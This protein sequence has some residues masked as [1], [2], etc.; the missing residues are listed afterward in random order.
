MAPKAPAKKGPNSK[1]VSV[2]VKEKRAASKK[3]YDFVY[4]NWKPEE[5]API[6]LK[7]TELCTRWVFGYEIGDSGTPHLQGFL[8]LKTKDRITGIQSNPELAHFSFRECRNEAALI[9]YCNGTG[10]VKK[11]TSDVIESHGF[12]TPVRIITQLRPW[13]QQVVDIILT[14]PN[15]RT[16]HW[17]ADEVGNT[18]KS[19]LCKYLYVRHG[20]L[21]IQGGKL[22]DIMNIIFNTNMDNVKA[23]VIDVP[24]TNRNRVSYAS[25]ECI[26]NGMITNT[27]Y[28]T[29]TK[30]FNAPHVLVMSN[31]YPDEDELSED[32][33]NIITI[34][35]TNN[36]I[37]EEVYKEVLLPE[38][39]CI[40]ESSD[41]ESC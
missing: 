16:I 35:N 32:R 13:Q 33:W 19:A 26:L 17:F 28:E 3:K 41:E 10:E 38:K 15:G 27:K 29:G 4:N 30:V 31:F 11:R 1:I 7:L 18:G 23:L 5:V 39:C 2:P 24:R 8:E 6:K 37:Q 40:E 20:V 34:D 14:E 12:P 25:I 21:V 22:A 36:A 9:A